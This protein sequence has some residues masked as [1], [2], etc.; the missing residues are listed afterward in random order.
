[1]VGGEFDLEVWDLYTKDRAKIEKTHIRGNKMSKGEYHLV[2]NVWIR[3]LKGEYLISQRAE[4]RSVNPLK[5]ECVCGSVLRG[6]SSV[7]G[8]VRETKEE[9]GIDLE[10]E[11]GKLVFTEACEAEYGENYIVDIWLFNYNGRIDLKNATTDEVKCAKWMK[12]DKIYE[13]YYKGCMV[14]TSTDYFDKVI[15]MA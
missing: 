3:N 13:L 5:F 2:V 11:T 6:E 1:M 15:H 9:V 12:I 7:E 8:A 10:A 4:T 14:W